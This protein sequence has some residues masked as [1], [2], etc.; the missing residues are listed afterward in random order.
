MSVSTHKEKGLERTLKALANSR[1]L[2]IVAFLKK[3][4]EATVGEIASHMKLSFRA[5]SRHLLLLAHADVLESEQRNINVFYKIA[6]NAA[7]V[8]KAILALL[9]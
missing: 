6:P 3:Q 1:R 9:K 7:P 8:C 5:T 2:A 4:K